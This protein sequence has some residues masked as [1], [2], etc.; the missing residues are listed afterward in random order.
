MATKRAPPRPPISWQPLTRVVGED[1]AIAVLLLALLARV[2]A[3]ARVDHAAHA[4]AV[5]DLEVGDLWAHLGHD[6]HN[7]VACVCG[8]VGVGGDGAWGLSRALARH[9][10]HHH[11]TTHHLPGTQG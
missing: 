10:H 5:A 8:G 4:S 7:L 11:T 9:H 3:A 2:A 1:G 6:A